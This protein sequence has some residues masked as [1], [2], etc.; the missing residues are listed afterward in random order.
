MFEKVKVAAVNFAP[1][2]WHPDYNADRLETL[3]CQAAKSGA[4]LVVAPEGILEGLVANEAIH[5]PELREAMLEVAERLDGPC[6]R[7]FSKL[8]RQFKS[9][10][11]FGMAELRGRRD[12]YNTAVFIGPRGK[13]CG[14]YSKMQFAEG[15]DSSWS[16]NRLGRTIRAFETPLGRCGILLCFD[17]WNPLLARALV[18]DGARFICIPTFGTRSKLQDEAVLAR[19]RE[20]GVP[21]VQANVGRNLVISKGEIVALD[22]RMDTITLA[23]IEIPAPCSQRAARAVEREFLSARPAAMAERLKKTL[24]DSDGFRKQNPHCGPSAP[25]PRNRAIAVRDHV[26]LVEGKKGHDE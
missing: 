5:F 2:K 18:L 13:V 24:A 4:E 19:A 22:R 21:V 10:I 11:V 8:A 23:E 7:R 3:F 16:F 6:V 26:K 20:N 12:I 17:R 14:A 15:Y 1:W 25:R 9:A